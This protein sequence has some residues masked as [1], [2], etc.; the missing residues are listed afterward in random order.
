MQSD[1][2]LNSFIFSWIIVTY[3]VGNK[4]LHLVIVLLNVHWF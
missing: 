4:S 2:S 1:C 3:H